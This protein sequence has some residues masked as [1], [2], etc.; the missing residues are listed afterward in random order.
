MGI[1]LRKLY[2]DTLVAM[3]SENKLGEQDIFSGK[4]GPDNDRGTPTLDAYSRDLTK[5][6]SENGLDPVER[7]RSRG[8]FRS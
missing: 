2:A 6:A 5:I 8:S 3:G 4:F 7:R 1:D